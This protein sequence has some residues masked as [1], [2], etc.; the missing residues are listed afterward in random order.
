M[1]VPTLKGVEMKVL[2]SIAT[3]M[4]WAVMVF[5]LIRG[6]IDHATCTGVLILIIRGR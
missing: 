2:K 5:C 6:Y 1:G 4:L 3:P